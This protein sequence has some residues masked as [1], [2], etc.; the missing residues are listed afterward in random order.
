MISRHADSKESFDM[1]RPRLLVTTARYGAKRYRRERD[2]PGAIAGL[3]ARPRNEI[4]P[5]LREAEEICEEERLTQS[6]AYR[7]GK[8]VQILAALLAEAARAAQPKASGSEAL[9][10]AT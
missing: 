4:V 2:L 3:L 1:S 8:H 10:S 6:A 9:R 7:P 5:R